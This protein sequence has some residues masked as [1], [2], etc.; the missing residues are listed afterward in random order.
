MGMKVLI[1]VEVDYPDLSMQKHID[2][3]KAIFSQNKVYGI[4][5]VNLVE[6]VL[7]TPVIIKESIYPLK[8]WHCRGTGNQ[9]VEGRGFD[10]DYCGGSGV[11]DDDNL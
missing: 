4:K 7:N 2:M 6:T 3:L 11:K 10:C 9:S 5:T 1:E 8:C